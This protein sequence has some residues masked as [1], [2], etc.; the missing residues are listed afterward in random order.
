MQS[1]SKDH[2]SSAQSDVNSF[3]GD[4]VL[5]LSPL[6][7]QGN[8]NVRWAF[9]AETRCIVEVGMTLGLHDR[10]VVGAAFRNDPAITPC[11]SRDE[12]KAALGNG[13]A[14]FE[15][16]MDE[17]GNR[18]FQH[19]FARNLDQERPWTNQGQ[20]LAVSA[21]RVKVCG[22]LRDAGAMLLAVTE[23]LD[24]HYLGTL[25]RAVVKGIVD[26]QGNVQHIEDEWATV[27]EIE[28]PEDDWDLEFSEFVAASA[29][30]AGAEREREI[31]ERNTN[32]RDKSDMS[33]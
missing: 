31:V 26:D 29:S 24:S 19:I 27:V 3:V 32:W 21:D 11:F 28:F 5:K 12:K 20:T 15:V 6:L 16:T 14:L 33:R 1:Q 4:A 8:P 13:D 30:R 25:Y 23:S 18:S 7:S 9:D 22:G 2:E 10:E 17:E